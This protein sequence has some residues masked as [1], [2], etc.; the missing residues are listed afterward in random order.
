MLND[1]G[2]N[3]AA[4]ALTSTAGGIT[5]TVN[6]SKLV[7]ISGGDLVPGAN[8][9]LDLGGSSARWANIYTSDMN[10]ANDRGDWTLIEEND[11]ISFRN[12]HTGRRFK[13]L[14][15]DITDTGDYGPD[16]D[17]NM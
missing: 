3:A 7:T 13:M 15:E 6:S 5:L 2:T 10:F 12:N 17:G 9:T 4:I 1:A 8:G 11:F 16:I 14:M